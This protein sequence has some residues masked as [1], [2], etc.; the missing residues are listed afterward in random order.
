MYIT[1]EISTF[2]I[3]LDKDPDLQQI[4]PNPAFD[5]EEKNLYLLTVRH[6]VKLAI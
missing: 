3:E 1:E 2:T 4:H 5:R 6:V